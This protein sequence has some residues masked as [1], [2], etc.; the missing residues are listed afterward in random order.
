MLRCIYF[1]QGQNDLKVIRYVSWSTFAAGPPI[2]L[3]LPS[4][5]APPDSGYDRPAKS[6][7][8]INLSQKEI[9][10]FLEKYALECL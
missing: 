8:H 1:N 7:L 5:P 9:R 4:P 10:R 3:P 2:R 6:T